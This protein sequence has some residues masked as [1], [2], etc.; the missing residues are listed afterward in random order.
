MTGVIYD[1][2]SV[3]L[4]DGMALF[5]YNCPEI[6]SDGS[7]LWV[8]S[9]QCA[10]GRIRVDVFGVSDSAVHGN[11]VN[12]SHSPWLKKVPKCPGRNTEKLRIPGLM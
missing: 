5:L 3:L 10:Q 4:N 9:C 11:V 2:C 7:I 12:S 8:G 6:T 1:R